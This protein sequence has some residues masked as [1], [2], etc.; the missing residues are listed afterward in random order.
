VVSGAPLRGE[1]KAAG[2]TVLLFCPYARR[3]HNRV[4][5][6]K[7]L[8]EAFLNCGFCSGASRVANEQVFNGFYRAAEKPRP[9]LR[10]FLAKINWHS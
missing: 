6:M 3:A 7:P 1:L 10:S 5:A 9:I 2:I 8:P 4:L